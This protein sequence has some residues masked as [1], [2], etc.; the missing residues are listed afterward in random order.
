MNEPLSTSQTPSRAA[1]AGRSLGRWVRMALL[2]TSVLLAYK[3]LLFP[4]IR[5]GLDPWAVDWPAVFQTLPDVI[6]PVVI[7]GVLFSLLAVQWNGFP[8]RQA[9]GPAEDRSKECPGCGL[10]CAATARVCDCGRL[11]GEGEGS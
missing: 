9:R 8:L 7:K 2:F 4:I 5:T 3:L 11:F 1:A 6:G 10:I